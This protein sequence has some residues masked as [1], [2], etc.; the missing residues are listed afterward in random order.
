MPPWGRPPGAR[1]GRPTGRLRKQLMDGDVRVEEID[2]EA[3]AEEA[4]AAAAAAAVVTAG[5][6]RGVLR[7]NEYPYYDKQVVRKGGGGGGSGGRH[8]RWKVQHSADYA[9][10]VEDAALV[11]GADY[12]LYDDGDA[13]VAYAVH[14]AMKDKEEWLVDKALERIRRAQAAGKQNVR[15]SQQELDAIERRRIQT[16]PAHGG[17][18]MAAKPIEVRPKGKPNGLSGG[19]HDLSTSSDETYGSWDQAASAS[20]GPQGLPNI[21]SS[22]SS[23]PRPR[24]PVSSLQSQYPQP[25]A[26]LPRT[27]H[28]PPLFPHNPSAPSLPD[29]PVIR[30][31]PRIQPDSVPYPVEP[32]PFQMPIPIPVP[33]SPSRRELGRLV[34]TSLSRPSGVVPGVVPGA[35]ATYSHPTLPSLFPRRV[36]PGSSETDDSDDKDARFVKSLPRKELA[37]A[38]RAAA[39]GSISPGIRQ[40][41]ARLNE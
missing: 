4:A 27:L 16:E 39:S 10:D 5:Y 14:L 40:R 17:K 36:P 7:N 11:D 18:K 22:T 34:D 13:T 38:P 33:T 29:N 32:S 9:E 31:K 2:S 12:D 30:R 37:D 6:S 19:S 24:T 35:G 25:T 26:I 21:S 15:L 23:S 1:M 8:S 41:I 3:E 28:G 20:T